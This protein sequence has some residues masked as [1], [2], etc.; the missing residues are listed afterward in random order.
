MK[1]AE[2]VATNE[3]FDFPIS[4]FELRSSGHFC[5]QIFYEFLAITLKIK[6]GKI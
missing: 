2:Y 5:T 4:F 3:K 1:D 6:I